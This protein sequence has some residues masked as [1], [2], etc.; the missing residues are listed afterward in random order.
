MAKREEIEDTKYAGIKRRI[1]DGKYIVSLDLGR[2]LRPDKETGEM[3]WRQVKTTRVVSTFRE[4]QDLLAENIK[5]KSKQVAT[6]RTR[7]VY[8]EDVIREYDK[9]H[10][11]L[12]DSYKGQQKAQAKRINAY[13]GRNFDARY[14]TVQDIEDFY[15]WCREE[16]P[17]EF[18]KA[19]SNNSIEKIRSYLNQLYVF[20]EKGGI[21]YS[22][23]ENI[24]PKTSV[25]KIKKFK[26]Q[27]LTAEQ[28]ND[29]IR[30]AL[31]NEKDYS[32][33][34]MIGLTALTGLRRG[35][36]CGVQWRDLM[37]E[38]HLINIVR[39]RVQIS[40]GSI[41]KTPKGGDDN[42]DTRD[43]R[44]ERYACLPYC[45]M[46]L[47]E[48]VKKQQEEYLHRKVKPTDYIYMTK[49]NLV[50]DYLPHPGKISR[51]FKEFQTRMNKVRA[52]AGKE[53]IPYVRLHDMRHTFI[54]LCVNGGVNPYQVSWNCGHLLDKR[55]MATTFSEY[56][57]DDDNREDIRKFMDGIITT[58]L[59]IPDM[60]VSKV[61]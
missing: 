55:D 56:L 5:K 30:F 60:T 42:A 39:Q 57:H 3:K 37:P 28:L 1:K 41:E 47:L 13:F 34:A 6:G 16:Q 49:I 19:L 10:K 43:E 40:T 21:K 15:E 32:I 23:P 7:R 48:Y 61:E 12:S 53:P 27:I 36:L 52:K 51:R 29:M 24:I 4:A 44:R 38:E 50:N 18:P 35:E 25:G 17:P 26:V 20:M 46:T 14:L 33:F 22:L 31:D 9:T 54:S 11:N 59:T 45:L 58:D 8:F 2:Q